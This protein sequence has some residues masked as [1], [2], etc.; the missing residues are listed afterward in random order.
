LSVVHS[1]HV[2]LFSGSSSIFLPDGAGALVFWSH[3]RR[4]EHNFYE[5]AGYF[6]VTWVSPEER[7]LLNRTMALIDLEIERSDSEFSAIYV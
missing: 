3:G 1:S 7:T 6:R 5:S 4:F 2:E